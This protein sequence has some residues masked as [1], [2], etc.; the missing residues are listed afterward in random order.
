MRDLLDDVSA[1]LSDDAR[2][3]TVAAYLHAALVDI[4]SPTATDAWLACS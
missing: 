2:S 1:H 4:L 3:L